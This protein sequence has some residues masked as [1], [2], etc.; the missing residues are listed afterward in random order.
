MPHIGAKRGVFWNTPRVTHCLSEEMTGRI[1]NTFIRS[2]R[3]PFTAPIDEYFK[4]RPW[5]VFP[6]QLD[7]CV[8]RRHRDD[9]LG[10]HRDDVGIDALGDLDLMQPEPA[11]P[12]GGFRDLQRDELIAILPVGFALLVL[13]LIPR[14]LISPIGVSVAATLRAL[15][16]KD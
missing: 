13:G 7:Q 16:F 10:R 5:K 2:E 12:S 8:S 1:L 14:L 11:A 3:F 6:Y 9:V 15:G 4:K